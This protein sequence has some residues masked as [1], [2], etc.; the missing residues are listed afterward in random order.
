MQ[1]VKPKTV[2]GGLTGRSSC[3]PTRR[4]QRLVVA[5]PHTALAR[6]AHNTRL[7]S[8]TSAGLLEGASAAAQDVGEL[9]LRRWV[10]VN[11]EGHLPVHEV[12][13]WGGLHGAACMPCCYAC[14]CCETVTEQL[15]N[16]V[17]VVVC[18]LCVCCWW[19]AGSGHAGWCFCSD[20][21]CNHC[22]QQLFLSYHTP[23]CVHAR[24]QETAPLRDTECDVTICA[25][26]VTA[27]Q[28]KHV[29]MAIVVTDAAAPVTGKSSSSAAARRSSGFKL[30]D[31]PKPMLHWG[32]V[33]GK[34]D[35]WQPP[36][37][38]W[39]TWPDVSHDARECSRAGQGLAN[40][41]HALLIYQMPKETVCTTT[42]RGSL[43]KVA[44]SLAAVPW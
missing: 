22:G 16:T 43:S 23:V 14:S 20:D 35:R 27:G 44:N 40:G 34:G 7:C 38:G 1:V 11:D 8:S 32:C 3:Y 10:G 33:A 6:P 31:L 9:L 21:R 36:P 5:Q 24:V 37:S 13:S 15:D 19:G 30:A 26:I 25:T 4:Q 12:R 2:S 42:A 29:L 17:W 18:W 41:S 39:S 28:R